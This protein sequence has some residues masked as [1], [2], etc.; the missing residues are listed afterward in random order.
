[1]KSKYT[2]ED[3]AKFLEKEAAKVGSTAKVA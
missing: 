1:V 2:S 3:L